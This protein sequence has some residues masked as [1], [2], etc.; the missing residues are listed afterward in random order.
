MHEMSL[1]GDLLDQVIAIAAQYH[2]QSVESITVNVGALA[3]VE[4]ALLDSAFAMI[5][6]GT[7]VEQAQLILHT[8]PVTVL[9]RVCGVQSE[10]V[11]NR[12]LCSTC[13]SHAT[14]LLSGDELILAS[15][16]LNCAD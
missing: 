15:V 3:G 16:T 11:A 10:V 12:L 1:C 2:A 14:T 6:L 9:C 5:K 8:I 7:V 13:Q 4:P